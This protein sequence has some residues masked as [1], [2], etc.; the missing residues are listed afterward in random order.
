LHMPEDLHGWYCPSC[1][2]ACKTQPLA[3]QGLFV[4]EQDHPVEQAA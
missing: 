2:P 4:K 3:T 1:C